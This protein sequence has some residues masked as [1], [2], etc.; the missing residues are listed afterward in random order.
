[1]AAAASSVAQPAPVR[2]RVVAFIEQRLQ[3][4]VFRMVRLHTTSPCLPAR[5]ARPATWVYSWQNALPS[6]NR[7]KT[8]RRP[9]PVRYQRHI[10]K[11]V[12][13][14]Q[15]LRAN[16]ILA[17]PRCT[18]ASCCSSAP[19]RRWY[20]GRY[21]KWAHQGITARASFKLFGAQP[22]GYQVRGTAGRAW[23]GTGRWLSQW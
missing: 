13:F 7:Q 16:Q 3:Q 5:P 9:H 22:H 17:P 2:Q 4:R 10:R 6:E 15:H 20:R 14:R 18:S 11:V 1:M 8:A 19:L 12:T 23:R 21:E